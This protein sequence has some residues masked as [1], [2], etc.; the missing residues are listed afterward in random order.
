MLFKLNLFIE[1]S[2]VMNNVEEWEIHGD[3]YDIRLYKIHFLKL[4][5]TPNIQSRDS[6]MTSKHV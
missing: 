2:C 4:H 3:C 6:T 5:I 1:S